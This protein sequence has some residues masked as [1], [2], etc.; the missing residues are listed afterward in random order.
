MVLETLNSAGRFHIFEIGDGARFYYPLERIASVSDFFQSL[1]ELPLPAGQE[2][3]IPLPMV[4]STGFALALQ[5]VDDYLRPPGMPRKPLVP[6][7]DSE[8]ASILSS[9]ASVLSSTVSSE[10]PDK[11]HDPLVYL[12]DA[13]LRALLETSHALDLPCVGE[14]LFTLYA[15]D[16][17][18]DTFWV[19]AAVAVSKTEGGMLR[20]AAWNTL[21]H[22]LD[23]MPPTVQDLLSKCAP[24]ALNELRTL[25]LAWHR[26]I[27]EF[28]ERMSAPRVVSMSISH[29]WVEASRHVWNPAQPCANI[30]RYGTP[31]LMIRDL[32]ARAMAVLRAPR[33]ANWE[34]ASKDGVERT[35]R[36]A[37][38]QCR[39]CA[40]FWATLYWGCVQC[41][42]WDKLRRLYKPKHLK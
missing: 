21:P 22:P 31:E 40:D 26:V 14:R 12:T 42:F 37:A 28:A 30:E 23:D 25:H 10:P 7:P 39:L 19:F 5:L 11:L 29:P 34:R 3:V 8:V 27:T 4:S 16:P 2:R 32:T 36:V 33:G 20:T 1:A 35:I 15:T 13:E 17:L 18:V 24:D 38:R 9:T 41:Y 6:E